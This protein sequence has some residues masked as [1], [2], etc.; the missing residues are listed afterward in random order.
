MMTNKPAE[1]TIPRWVVPVLVLVAAIGFGWY[2]GTR[3]TTD[4]AADDPATSQGV[5]GEVHRDVAG[6]V[7]RLAP[8]EGSFTVDHEEIEGFMAAMVMDLNVADPAELDGLEPGDEILF[9]L[10]RIG[11]RYEAVHIRRVNDQGNAYETAADTTPTNPLGPGDLVPDL[12]LHNADGEPF[13]LR[14]MQPRHKIVTFFYARCPIDTFCP[15]QAERLAELQAH[16]ESQGS[17]VHLLSITL[18][19]EHDVP[20]VLSGYADRFDADPARWT[21]AGGDDGDAIRDFA[22]RAGGRVQNHPDTYEIDHALIALR[23]DGDRIVDRVYGLEAIE[24]LI[25]AMP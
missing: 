23:V 13:R 25:R 12:L 4:H 16:I 10:A 7:V 24:N 17:D 11:D 2:L 19:P 21:L 14:Q 20:S 5:D 6:R 15:A 3:V 8:D 18:D 9:D 22:H 1:T